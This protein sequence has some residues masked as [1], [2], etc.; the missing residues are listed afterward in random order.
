MSKRYSTGK[1]VSEPSDKKTS[2]VE[3]PK[4]PSTSK[5]GP[6]LPDET[7]K[8]KIPKVPST[9]KKCTGS[10]NKTRKVEMPKNPSLCCYCNDVVTQL[11][12]TC[13]W[14]QNRG[15]CPRGKCVIC[16]QEFHLH[17]HP[18]FVC[19]VNKYSNANHHNCK[20]C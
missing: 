1:N 19:Q 3:K 16:T 11:C 10:A 5:K 12:F 17:C 6:D 13:R 7:C 4:I 2:K 20:H 8:F 15:Q 14:Y 9:S 18:K